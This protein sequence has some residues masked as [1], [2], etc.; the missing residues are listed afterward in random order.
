MAV[1]GEYGSTLVDEFFL[2]HFLHPRLGTRNYHEIMDSSRSQDPHGQG[3]HVILRR[4]ERRLL[5]K[6][7]T[8]KHNF[9]GPPAP[10][11]E[12][13][14]NYLDLTLN[15][16]DDPSKGIKDGQLRITWYVGHPFHTRSIG[17]KLTKNPNSDDLLQMFKEPVDGTLSL[18]DSQVL[19]V[20][21]EYGRTK[22]LFLSGGFSAN[23]YL[24]RKVQEQ[25]RRHGMN[26]IQ[27]EDW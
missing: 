8:V 1:G 16:P 21:A 27:A 9:E 13:L 15:I 25:A 20:D 23:K 7:I 6:F 19:Q 10:G 17:T 5:Q 3:A 2:Q 14:D 12:P 4:E 26:V 22:T 24:F 11:E 18:I